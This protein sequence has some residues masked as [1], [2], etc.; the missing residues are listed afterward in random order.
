MYKP[1]PKIKDSV[2]NFC[3]NPAANYFDPLGAVMTH[4]Q[5]D[6]NLDNLFKSDDIGF[7]KDE[8]TE[9]A[10]HRIEAFEKE[11]EFKEG[12]Y[13]K[14]PWLNERLNKVKSNFTVA[15]AVASKVA[16]KLKHS[17]QFEVYT[18]VFEEQLEA[19]VIE[20][21]DLNK[22]NP[23]DHVW[24]THRPVIREDVQVT[25][26][27][28]PVLNCSLKIGDGFSLNE[29]AFPGVNL[30]QNIFN[31]L[32]RIRFN[33]ILVMADSSKAFLQIKLRDDCDKNRFSIIWENV[34]GGEIAF[35][36][37]SLVFGFITSP[38]I[39][40]FIIKRHV[41]KF[42]S[43]ECSKV[44]LNNC[45][46]DNLYFTGNNFD[47]LLKLYETSV[48]RMLKGGFNLRSW[49]SNEVKLNSVFEQDG[50]STQHD[51]PNEKVLGYNYYPETDQLGLAERSV[52]MELLTKRTVLSR[53]A[54]VFDPLGLCLPVIVRGKLIMRSIWK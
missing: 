35:R 13:V 30:M 6:T 16:K 20:K 29:S 51:S 7:A 23:Y 48:D 25:T 14:L 19:G 44:L 12:K 28:R 53:L 15:K 3:I 46:V 8:V 4:S 1:E 33:K 37:T 26:K 24:I 17:G 50:V 27:V 9:D 45:Y 5:V 2:I 38:F 31:L 47:K 34:D 42:P 43:D 18:Q 36:Y 49:K 10:K 40:N 21:V 41:S 11:V 22:V 52:I 54:R 32:I 39:L